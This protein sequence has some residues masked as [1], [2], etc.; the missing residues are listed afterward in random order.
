MQSFLTA[1][2]VN[3]RVDELPH[4]YGRCKRCG[5]T[6]LTTPPEDLERY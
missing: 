4:E 3:R 2:D 5:L 1:I 6:C